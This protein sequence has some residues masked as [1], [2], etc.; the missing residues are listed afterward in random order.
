MFEVVVNFADVSVLAITALF[1]LASVRDLYDPLRV[2]ALRWAK[3]FTLL[4]GVTTSNPSV[5]GW[6][7]YHA[8]VM[9]LVSIM[10][11]SHLTG[12]LRFRTASAFRVIR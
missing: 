11:G 12:G 7:L 3:L 2:A 1:V 8:M 4:F 9:S 10:P 5:L 6:V